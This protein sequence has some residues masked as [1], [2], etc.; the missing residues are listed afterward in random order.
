MKEEDKK[1]K[2]K[3]I[4]ERGTDAV[5]KKESLLKKLNSGKPLRIKHGID[6]TGP[7]IHIGRAI[8]FWKLKELQE[9]GHKIILI[10]GDFTAQIGDASDKQYRQAIEN[11]LDYVVNRY[12]AYVDVWEL[13]NEIDVSNDWVQYFAT[14]LKKIDPLKRP[15]TVNWV[16]PYI[17]EVDISS[18][19]WYST[20]NLSETDLAIK[21]KIEFLQKWDKP[22]VF[23]EIGNSNVSWDKNSALRMRIKIW[24]AYFKNASF[25]F[26]N[27]NRGVYKHPNNCANIYLG[28][29]ERKY[30]KAFRKF[31]NNV[32]E[33]LNNA[34]VQLKEQ[35]Q[36]RSYA[37]KSPKHFLAY[38]YHFKNPDKNI[39]INIKINLA[40]SGNLKWVKPQTGEIIR[41]ED[42]SAGENTLQSPLFEEDLALKIEYK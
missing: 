36:V 6:P 31:V 28:P 18:A 42:V 27:T 34:E 5:I 20:E 14:Y 11:Y 15:V 26:W 9:L 41:K 24:T 22:I 35:D 2:I 16:K 25:I 32:K 8:S 21:S 19:H 38:F 4:L 30:T 7:K 23:S 10:I 33:N 3:N 37:L 40:N 39:K 17:E 29:E 13:T 12:G 1:Q